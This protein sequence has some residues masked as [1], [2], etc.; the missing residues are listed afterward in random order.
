MVTRGS[1]KPLLRVRVLLPLPQWVALIRSG[2]SLFYVRSHAFHLRAA[3]YEP[4]K[5]NVDIPPLLYYDTHVSCRSRGKNLLTR[6]P[7]G[8]PKAYG[9]PGQLP[10]VGFVPHV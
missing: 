1:P 3:T 10:S 9:Q 5:K 6:F 2:G 4:V 7:H 8:K